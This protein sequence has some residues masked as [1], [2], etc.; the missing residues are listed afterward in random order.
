MSALTIDTAFV[1]WSFAESAW[2][3]PGG[4][5]TTNELRLA[6][7]YSAAECDTIAPKGHSR[8]AQPLRALISD[9][10][11]LVY[12]GTVLALLRAEGLL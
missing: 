7:C 6:G 1:V 12:D 11:T 5:S 4:F 3:A 9:P 10:P 8:M 2:L